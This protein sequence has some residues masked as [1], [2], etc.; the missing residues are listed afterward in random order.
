MNIEN[1]TKYWKW[2]AWTLP[3][4]ALA[5]IAFAYWIDDSGLFGKFIVI[6]STV[7]FGISVFWWWWALD[8]LSIL[9]KERL[10]FEKKFDEVV[11][12]FKRLR[13][14]INDSDR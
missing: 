1:Q 8:K 10:S 12:E 11:A 2:A 13:K 14:D 3:F 6:T 5:G 4:I 9:I 7:F